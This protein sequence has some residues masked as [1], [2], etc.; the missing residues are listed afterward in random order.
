MATTGVTTNC[1]RIAGERL[2][3]NTRPAVEVGDGE[4]VMR[5]TLPV[6]CRSRKARAG[7]QRIPNC[8]GVRESNISTE[9]AASR[10]IPGPPIKLRATCPH[11]R[12]IN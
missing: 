1:D 2:A 3:I 10:S 4:Q 5:P 9:T 7:A 8:R 6:V 12:D 11:G